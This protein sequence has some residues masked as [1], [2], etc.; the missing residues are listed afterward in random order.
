AS[1]KAVIEETEKQIAALSQ[2]ALVTLRQQAETV[3]RR[4]SE[5]VARDLRRRLDQL[6]DALQQ[7]DMANTAVKEPAEYPVEPW[8]GNR[9]GHCELP[10]ERQRQPRK[11]PP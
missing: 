4:T 2:A 6:A 1:G 7:A 3:H 10:R 11:F 5:F 8:R 9:A